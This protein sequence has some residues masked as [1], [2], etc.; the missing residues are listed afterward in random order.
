MEKPVRH[1]GQVKAKLSVRRGPLEQLVWRLDTSAGLV[2]MFSVALLLRIAIAPQLGFY[3][4]LHYFQLW[5][6]ELAKVG[7]H[8]FYSVEG[9]LDYP[10][11]YVYVLWLTGKLSATPSYLL[12]KLPAILGDVGLAWVAGTFASRLAPASVK[13]RLPVRP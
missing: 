13:E 5:A 8:K 7:P 1:G 9:F 11:G 6:G 4:D 12:L 10:P 2:T 3:S